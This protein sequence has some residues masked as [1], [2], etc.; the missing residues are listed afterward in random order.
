MHPNT[1]RT[2]YTSK[3]TTKHAA[4]AGL[5]GA[6]TVAV[7]YVFLHAIMGDPLLTT[8]AA[9][10]TLLFYGPEALATGPIF[11]AT[12]LVGYTLVHTLAFLGLGAGAVW[13]ARRIPR[14]PALGAFA[15]LAFVLFEAVAVIFSRGVGEVYGFPTRELELIVANVLAASAMLGYIWS[16]ATR[17]RETFYRG[18]WNHPH[19][20]DAPR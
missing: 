6:G 14:Q 18:M 9:L 7:W 5:I 4:T 11:N 16:R 12:T 2:T 3:L 13:L 19:L 15:I 8:P 10:G 20:A 1:P 17:V